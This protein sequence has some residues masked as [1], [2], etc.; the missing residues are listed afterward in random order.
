MSVE[1]RI[2]LPRPVP[3]L[4]KIAARISELG[5]TLTE[6]N[7]CSIALSKAGADPEQ[8]RRWGGDVQITARATELDLLVNAVGLAENVTEKVLQALA[9][10]GIHTT[11]EEV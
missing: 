11:A 9:E 3:S 7:D 5:L 1:Y 6:S 2:A 8:Q 4:S 10:D